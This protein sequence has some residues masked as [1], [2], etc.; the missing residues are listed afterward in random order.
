M[1]LS[2][3][4]TSDEW[5]ACFYASMGKCAGDNFGDSMHKTIDAL[6]KAGYTFSGLDSKGNRFSP[7]GD[8]E[9]APKM[10]IF[11]GKLEV[12]ILAI[13]INGRNFLKIHCPE[14]VGETDNEFELTIKDIKEQN[15]S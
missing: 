8:I 11:F 9:N 7:V 6:L 4:L 1:A 3:Y 14:L 5:D 13:Y 10:S 12:D 2:S 15:L